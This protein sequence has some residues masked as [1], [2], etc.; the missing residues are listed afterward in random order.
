MMDSFEKMVDML[1]TDDQCVKDTELQNGLKW[2][3]MQAD[4]EGLSFYEMVF[5]IFEMHET[6]KRAKEWLR[7]KQC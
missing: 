2:V 1:L 6:R 5:K 4:K 7:D 3:S